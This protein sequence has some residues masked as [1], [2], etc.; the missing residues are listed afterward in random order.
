MHT[1]DGYASLAL[2]LNYITN[3]VLELKEKLAKIKMEVKKIKKQQ[4]VIH[5]S[6]SYL[7]KSRLLNNE[8]SYAKNSTLILL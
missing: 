8:K 5:L 4:Q 6:Q 3:I 1:P 7:L 2:Q